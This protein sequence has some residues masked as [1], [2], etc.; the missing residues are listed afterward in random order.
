MPILLGAWEQVPG[1]LGPQHGGRYHPPWKKGDGG[2]F[3]ADG[4]LRPCSGGRRGLLSPAQDKA[5]A[6][7][8]QHL[9]LDAL[10]CPKTPCCPHPGGSCFGEL[11]PRVGAGEGLRSVAGPRGAAGERGYILTCYHGNGSSSVAAGRGGCSSPEMLTKGRGKGAW[12]RQ[13]WPQGA[14][15]TP[16]PGP[17]AETPSSAPK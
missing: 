14:A 10:R 2:S 3:M 7:A 5:T 13:G 9:F 16:S 1:C 4:W 12:L 8:G 6:T 11:E 17:V 15:S